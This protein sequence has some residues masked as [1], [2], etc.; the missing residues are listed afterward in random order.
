MMIVR[1]YINTDIILSK[2]SELDIYKRYI[3]DINV[4]EMIHSPLRG[5]DNTPSFR[6]QYSNNGRLTFID[7]GTGQ[8]GDVF[9]FVLL[10][11]PML[12][13]TD[14]LEKV[15]SDMNCQIIPS[16][17]I[18][19]N[20][21]IRKQSAFP[22]IRI[23]RRSVKESDILWWASWGISKD[24]L[25]KFRVIPISRFYL[26]NYGWWSCRTDCYA[27]DLLNEWKIYRPHEE[28]MRFISGGNTLQGY[29]LLPETGDICII[30]KSYKDVMLMN[31]FN[32]ASFAPQAES[33][34]VPEHIMKDI[35][36]RFIHVYIWGDPDVSGEAFVKRHVDRYGIKGIFNDD[37]TKDI[38]D[39]CR[40]YGKQ[41]TQDLIM[42]SL[43]G[44]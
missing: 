24:T 1:K 5:D 4:K 34:D 35:L 22:E 37:D 20:K 41:S 39:H 12:G 15:Y 17:Y 23:Q 36:E 33:I 8:K 16:R 21:K 2:V 28:T 38:T 11:F 31:E 26:E 3:G 30:Q 43:N 7:F 19:N 13:F 25:N 29:D 9:T 6:L 18:P 40:K 14:M 42:R 44:Q 10:M 27:Y 32:I